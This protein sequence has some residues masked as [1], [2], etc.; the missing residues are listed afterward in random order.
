MKGKI[1]DNKKT[2]CSVFFYIGT[3]LNLFVYCYN[4][5]VLINYNYSN[6][7]I[8]DIYSINFI[9]KNVINYSG[10]VQSKLRW[11]INWFNSEGK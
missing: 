5:P 3:A 6:Y 11:E 7:Y 1:K 4:N 9:K 8:F 2:D 10:D